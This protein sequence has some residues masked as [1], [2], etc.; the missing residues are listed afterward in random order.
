MKSKGYLVDHGKYDIGV[1]L[2]VIKGKIQ[3]VVVYHWND[4]DSYY[5]I[6]SNT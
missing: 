1:S 3:I 2:K 5:S 4:I 6:I